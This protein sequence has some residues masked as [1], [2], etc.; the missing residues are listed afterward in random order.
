MMYNKEKQI[1]NVSKIWT[2]PKTFKF[3]DLHKLSFFFKEFNIDSKFHST[4]SFLLYE[5]K[6]PKSLISMQF[7]MSTLT[8]T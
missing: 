5:K 8:F 3:H 6:I 7:F 2:L 4:A 1:A